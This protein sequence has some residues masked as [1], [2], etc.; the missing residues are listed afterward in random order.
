MLLRFSVCLLIPLVCA[1]AAISEEPLSV[2]LVWQGKLDLGQSQGTDAQSSKATLIFEIG[3]INKDPKDELVCIRGRRESLDA[4]FSG[5]P[6]AYSWDGVK[7]RLL[8]T[9]AQKL[10]DVHDVA[11]D[12][13]GIWMGKRRDLVWCNMRFPDWV[14]THYNPTGFALPVRFI[15]V[16]KEGAERRFFVGFLSS[17]ETGPAGIFRRYRFATTRLDHG[18]FKIETEIT[19]TVTS[20]GGYGD[21]LSV[22]ARDF[23]GD[24]ADEVAIYAPSH[25]M[26]GEFWLLKEATSSRLVKFAESPR[27]YLI[28]A[29][30][31]DRDGRVELL[32]GGSAYQGHRS[33]WCF[34]WRQDTLVFDRSISVPGEDGIG[35]YLLGDVMNNA[36]AELLVCRR[37]SVAVYSF[38]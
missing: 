26:R 19:G 27:S 17:L 28:G 11:I 12:S 13:G 20:W 4:G 5:D 16:L 18:L 33:P 15:D 6:L 37:D 22:V 30:D 9:N 29:A 31:V 35:P 24:G 1:T 14:I 34:E 10:Y 3:N 2:S 36:D 23:D 25:D 21:D 7:F 38:E 8:R 32:V